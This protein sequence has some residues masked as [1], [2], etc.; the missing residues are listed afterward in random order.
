MLRARAQRVLA[1]LVLA[2]AAALLLAGSGQGAPTAVTGRI[3][4]A[5]EDA[6]PGGVSRVVP[7]LDTASGPIALNLS[8]GLPAAPGSRV[9][10][11]DPQ[12]ANGAIVG[13][14]L[15][16]PPNIPWPSNPTL[17]PANFTPG[18]KKAL[19]LLVQPAGQSAPGSADAIRSAVFTAPNSA[20]AFIQQ[21]SYGQLSLVG[22]L[23][24]D[25]D[26]YGPYPVTSSSPALCDNVN[27]GS[28]A[29]AAFKTAT[30]MD[31]ETWNHVIVVFSVPT[32]ICNFSGVGEIGQTGDY[33]AARHVWINAVLSGGVPTTS[34]LAHELGHNLGVDH[35]GVLE[36]MLGTVRVS[37]TLPCASD[38]PS[39]DEDQYL[40]PFDV[41]GNVSAREES[42]YH[43][44]ESG[45]LPSSAV[46][47][48]A[49]SGTYLIAPVETAT[50][51][52]QLLEV[53]RA[54]GAASYWLDFRQPLAGA[55]D[56]FAPDDPA[57]N[58]VT[59]RYANSSTMPHPAKS[60]LIDTTPATPSF[61]DAPLAV[62]QT[63]TDST[64]GVSIT[65]LGVS[66]LGAL[67]RV[68]VPATTDTTPPGAPGG[69]SAAMDNGTV[70]LSWTAASDNLGMVQH[71]L[72]RRNGVQLADAYGTT[73]GDPNPIPGAMTTYDVR[74][75]DPAGNIGPAA[76]IQVTVADTTAPSAPTG[77]TASLSGT[78]VSLGWGAALD[79]VGVA[80]Y[81]VDRDGI[82][83]ARGLTGTSFSDPGIAPGTHTYVVRAADAAGN[84]GAFSAAASVT[85]VIQAATPAPVKKSVVKKI[86]AFKLKRLGTHRVLVSWKAQ[87]GA[88][89]YQVLRPSG[90]KTVLLAT[91]RKAQWID[92]HAARGALSKK[93]YVVRA[94]I[95]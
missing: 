45:W 36:C 72:V 95:S 20:N 68:T 31:P 73:T 88:V 76:T 3:M 69:I 34:V 21:E 49:T 43:R 83:L 92:G 18:P 67:V 40:D 9:T 26:V 44:W 2:G 11:E 57:V 85:L 81:E 41:M 50:S 94:V 65:T 13:G 42:A 90:K 1:G 15:L 48:V 70:R 51:A 12:Y 77:L 63:Y 25:G 64:Y 16:G 22:K 37:F 52:L 32:S 39:L 14:A 58:G 82:V 75:V 28:Q 86:S 74:A 6:A 91:V 93:R 27:W 62:G 8:D 35:A 24:S 23:R 55:F 59:I 33:G 5:H 38:T 87:K 4:V 7:L 61:A 29:E 47:T 54:S 53:P 19:V 10:I 80:S 78:T 30:G 79:D 17:G 60:W 84:V 56:D 71:Y 89:H 46:Q 66:P